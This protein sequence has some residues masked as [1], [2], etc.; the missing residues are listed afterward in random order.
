M[1]S[2]TPPEP[3]PPTTV[4]PT[5]KCGKLNSTRSIVSPLFLSSFSY[6]HTYISPQTDE[7]DETDETRRDGGT[8][9]CITVYTAQCC[10]C[11][12]VCGTIT[13]FWDSTSLFSM[14]VIL[15]LA[16][17]CVYSSMAKKCATELYTHTHTHT[18]TP[19]RFQTNV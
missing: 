11:V 16:V 6:I 2:I 14:Y 13:A 5:R 4:S 18:H 9:A 15:Y 7:T 8:C 10:I 12:E 19:L 1:S 3:P 17:S